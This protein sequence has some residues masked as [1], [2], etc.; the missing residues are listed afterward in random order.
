MALF[1][2]ARSQRR[3]LYA[4]AWVVRLSCPARLL[5]PDS[6]S[7]APSRHADTPYGCAWLGRLFSFGS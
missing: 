7:I 3:G 1:L 5:T 6:G 2:R 4:L